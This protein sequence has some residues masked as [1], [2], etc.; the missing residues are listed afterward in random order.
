M[1]KDSEDA[2]AYLEMYYPQLNF[3]LFASTGM[4]TAFGVTWSKKKKQGSLLALPV[5]GCFVARFCVP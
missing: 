4:A 1:Q 2:F 3:N 5:W